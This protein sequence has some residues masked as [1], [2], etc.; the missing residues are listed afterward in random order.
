MPSKKDSAAARRRQKKWEFEAYKWVPSPQQQ[1]EVICKCFRRLYPS[2]DL[3]RFDYETFL[4][5]NDEPPNYDWVSKKRFELLGDWA[6]PSKKDSTA[7]RRKKLFNN[8]R[9]F[10]WY[11]SCLEPQKFQKFLGGGATQELLGHGPPSGNSYDNPELWDTWARDAL[12]LDGDDVI[13][14]ALRTAFYKF[15]LNPVDPY[16]WRMLLSLFA[17]VEFG[18]RPRGK[19]G[20]PKKYDKERLA[21]LLAAAKTIGT[22]LSDKE[23][24]GRLARDPRFATKKPTGAGGREG[25][26]KAIRKAR[27]NSP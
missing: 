9:I 20:A 1:Y 4:K 24:A 11:L 27:R 14:D 10:E 13:S 16:S 7:A 21:E 15:N 17:Y 5:L 22:G 6:I 12:K 3:K 8:E 25:L 26:R 19:A 2:F 23:I 18:K